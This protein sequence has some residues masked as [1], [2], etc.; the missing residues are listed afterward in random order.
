MF[1]AIYIA[2]LALAMFAAVRWRG[3]ALSWTATVLIAGNGLAELLPLIG[4]DYDPVI[5]LLVDLAMVAAIAAPQ[6]RF[7]DRELVIVWLF[8]PAWMLLASEDLWAVNATTLLV[9]AQLLLTVPW[10]WISLR[11]QSFGKRVR[12]RVRGSARTVHA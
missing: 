12:Q 7:K 10:S 2:A 11:L 5:W 1:D 4:V 9:S 6:W 3:W 8:L